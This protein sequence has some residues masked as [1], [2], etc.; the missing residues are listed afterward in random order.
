MD[1]SEWDIDNFKLDKVSGSSD[2]IQHKVTT[3]LKLAAMEKHYLNSNTT[4]SPRIPD[5]AQLQANTVP[6]PPKNP[7]H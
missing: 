4:I 3:D 5:K 6:R 1:D 7:L 2:D